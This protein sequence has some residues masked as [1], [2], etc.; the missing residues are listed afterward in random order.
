MDRAGEVSLSVQALN[1]LSEKSN[2]SD[3]TSMIITA[4]GGEITVPAADRDDSDG[5]GS[6]SPDV[7]QTDEINSVTIDSSR[8]KETFTI[9]SA[10]DAEGTID[11]SVTVIGAKGAVQVSNVVTLKFTGAPNAITVGDPS[12]PLGQSGASITVEVTAV[13]KSG[14]AVALTD[15]AITAKIK[16]RSDTDPS[17]GTIIQKGDADD[18]G[19]VDGTTNEDGSA[20]STDAPCASGNGDDAR[21]T[22]N[23]AA[24]FTATPKTHY[25]EKSHDAKTVV[26]P[27]STGDEKG[28]PW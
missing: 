26:I 9:K 6:S 21:T 20:L 5:I 23:E 4:F 1:S 2:D 22:E 24:G 16:D 27:V 15:E 28:Q 12:G 3:V 14:T 11:V 19:C 13:D 8:A 7:A 10:N 17:V 18:D 25:V